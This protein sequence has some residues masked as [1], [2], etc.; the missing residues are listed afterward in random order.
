MC[1]VGVVCPRYTAVNAMHHCVAHFFLFITIFFR[2]HHSPHFVCTP[3][4]RMGATLA[5]A[6][7]LVHTVHNTAQQQHVHT[8]S[9][10]PK[11]GHVYD[12]YNN[13]TLVTVTDDTTGHTVLR[14][15]IPVGCAPS[16]YALRT[17]DGGVM[18]E[19]Q[20]GEVVWV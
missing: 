14:E 16:P 2:C 8:V 17:L 7:A 20:C 19:F 18:L 11:R 1:G 10:W 5:T 9:F 12:V 4:K 3:K 15:W 6:A 13:S